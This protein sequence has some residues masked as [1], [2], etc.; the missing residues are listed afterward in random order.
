LFE[1]VNG[2]VAICMTSGSTCPC[3]E[4]PAAAAK[5]SA[6]NRPLFITSIPPAWE[7]VYQFD[8]GADAVFHRR[9]RIVRAHGEFADYVRCAAMRDVDVTCREEKAAT[10]AAFSWHR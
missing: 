9:Q 7:R 10:R 6:A 8:R 3:V 1:H 5:H 2:V 4:H